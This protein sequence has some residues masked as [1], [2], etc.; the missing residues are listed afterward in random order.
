MMNS[1][2]IL[3]AAP[4]PGCVTSAPLIEIRNISK[5]FGNF[6]ANRD[7]S[8]QIAKGEIHAIAGENGAGKTTLM[9]VLFGRLRPDSGSIILR[10]SPVSFRTCREAIRAGIGMVH[11]DILFFPQLSVLENIILGC[12]RECGRR[13][14]ANGPTP[15]FFAGVLRTG[16]AREEASRIQDSLGFH[17]EW[18]RQAKELSFARRQQIELVRLLYRGAEILILDEPTS[19][20]SPGETEKFLDLMKSLRAGGRT[21]LFISHRLSEVFS[22]ADRITVL[23]KGSL[24]ATLDAGATDIEEI[25]RLRVGG[26][27]GAVAGIAKPKHAADPGGDRDRPPPKTAGLSEAAAPL[28]EL[29]NMCVGP[30]GTEPALRDISISIGKGEIFGIGGVV[31]N[32]QRSLARVLAWKTCPDS[33][34]VRFDGSEISRPDIRERLRRNIRWLPENPVEEALLP[35]RPLWENFLL[36][37][38]REKEFERVGLIRKRK[39]IRFSQ[40]QVSLHNIAA[41]GPLEPLLGLS[42]GNRQKVALARVLAGPPLL[43]I[44]EQ[45]CRGLDLH[46]AGSIHE[47]LLEL[48]RGRGISFILISYDF[49]ELISICDRIAVIYRGEIMGT[50]E[51]A[52]VSRELLG[53]W[54]AGVKDAGEAEKGVPR[55][56]TAIDRHA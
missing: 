7:I 47:R 15:S 2:P 18:D 17:L 10:G 27:Q 46:A 33:G 12:E 49:D 52:K 20:L 36:G 37:R 28:L 5:K 53:R 21:V 54:A 30:S 14:G 3:A 38:Q 4:P 35:E 32:G 13:K 25:A 31:G 23:R 39:I 1:A 40:E 11:Q 8:L 24:T 16:R 26:M 45:P 48:S 51:S 44:L 55:T 9:N 50:A 29:R 42:G 22:V 6:Y 43:A 19:L 41:P 56:P 34:W